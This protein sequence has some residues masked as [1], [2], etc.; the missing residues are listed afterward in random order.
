MGKKDYAKNIIKSTSYSAINVAST[1]APNSFAM[2]RGLQSV[3]PNI[4][5][6]NS[7][8]RTFISNSKNGIRQ[9]LKNLNKNPVARSAQE[10]L[11]QAKRDLSTGNFA[12][13]SQPVNF[14]DFNFDDFDDELSDAEFSFDDEPMGGNTS[15]PK[16]AK[17][18]GKSLH[19]NTYM[20]SNS[21]YDATSKIGGAILESHNQN[22]NRSLSAMM[23]G[24][25]KVD[26][27]LNMISNKL[28]VMNENLVNI[29][30]FNNN[31]ITKVNTAMLDYFDKSLEAMRA[32]GN[33]SLDKSKFTS[34]VDALSE[35]FSGGFSAKAYKKMVKK[36]F[37]NSLIGSFMS[38]FMPTSLSDMRD[39]KS[40]AQLFTLDNITNGKGLVQLGVEGLIKAA[41]PKDI[42][43]ST[44]SLD[45]NLQL[46]LK[47]SLLKLGDKG[48]EGLDPISMIAEIFGYKQENPNK[49]KLSAYKKDSMDWNGIAQRT[50]VD[51]I[52]SLLA[53]ISAGVNNKERE[54]YNFDK[55]KF[56]TKEDLEKQLRGTFEKDISVAM[57]DS[58]NLLNQKI[59]KNTKADYDKT[60]L[61]AE[62]NQLITKRL[63][64]EKTT[65]STFAPAMVEKLKDV[66]PMQD[67]RSIVMTM[68][69]DII[70]AREQIAKITREIADGYGEYSTFRQLLNK[71]AEIMGYYDDMTI[72][73]PE[74]RYNSSGDDLTTNSGQMRDT[75]KSSFQKMKDKLFAP[76]N[77]RRDTTSSVGKGYKK[78]LNDIERL[79]FDKIMNTNTKEIDQMADNNA[80]ELMI[81]TRRNEESAANVRAR[82][83][84]TKPSHTHRRRNSKS[85]GRRL[86]RPN[87]RQLHSI[88]G[89][90]DSDG[91]SD[92][93][94]AILSEDLSDISE[95]ISS[96]QSAVIEGQE[97]LTRSVNAQQAQNVGMFTKF[98]A[99]FA[100]K[101]FGK[102]GI[103]TKFMNNKYFKS[104]KDKTVKFLFGNYKDGKFDGES[105]LF[106]NAGNYILDGVDYLR[107]A[108]TGKGFKGRVMQGA[109][110]D[111]K[112]SVIGY[113]KDGFKK[114]YDSILHYMF[115][116]NY[117]EESD[118][119]KRNIQ[120]IENKFR[121]KAS[122]KNVDKE[123]ENKEPAKISM[124]GKELFKG[125]KVKAIHRGS[126]KTGDDVSVTE[127]ESPKEAIMRVTADTMSKFKSKVNKFT[128]NIVGEDEDKK[129]FFAKFK[130]HLPKILTAGL[131]GGGLVLASG[132]SVGLLPSLFL[133]NN[134]IGGAIV[135]MGALFASKSES[136]KKFLFGEKDELG[137]RNGGV[138]G[139]KLQSSFKKAL[140][141][142]IGAGALG[143]IRSMA[144]GGIGIPGAGFLMNI[145]TPGGVV[146]AALLS[147]AG[148]LA[149]KSNA[150]QSV[151]FGDL[152]KD[153]VFH[154]KDVE[155]K[156]SIIGRALNKV[157]AGLKGSKSAVING[158]KGAG[159]GLG[160][161]MVVSNLGVLGSAL[162]PAGPIGTA[163]L[164]AAVGIAS[165]SDKFQTLMFG[166]KKY[167]KDGNLI[168]GERYKDGLIS[169]MQMYIKTQVV[170]PT[171][172]TIQRNLVDFGLWTVKNIKTPFQLAFGPMIDSVRTMK[173]TFTDTIKKFFD[174]VSEGVISSIKGFFSPAAKFF[175]DYI[176]KP[177]GKTANITAKGGL[178]IAGMAIS[179]P[180]QVLSALMAPQRH[181]VEREFR[182]EY[183]QNSYQTLLNKWASDP[184]R[185]TDNMNIFQKLGEYGNRGFEYLNRFFDR[186]AIDDFREEYANRGYRVVP[187][188]SYDADG[189]RVV[190]NQVKYLNSLDWFMRPVKNRR[191]RQ[192][193]KEEWNPFKKND[194]AFQKARRNMVREQGGISDREYTED[195]IK[196]I[197]KRFKKFGVDSSLLRNTDDINSMLYNYDKWND[198][199][200]R[201]ERGQDVNSAEFIQERSKAEDR[202]WESQERFQENVINSFKDGSI[203]TTDTDSAEILQT[204]SDA[205]IEESNKAT[206]F[207]E[208][209]T[210]FFDTVERR[211]GES[212]QAET[213]GMV[214]AADL[215][216]DNISDSEF[217]R[218]VNKGTIT[219]NEAENNNTASI[220][221]IGNAVRDAA[222]DTAEGV[223]V[224]LE[225]MNESENRKNKRDIE[226]S[227][228]REREREET[229]AAKGQGYA[230]KQAKITNDGLVSSLLGSLG[231]NNSAKKAEKDS[232]FTK[233]F[234]GGK[235]LLNTALS[236]PAAFASIALGLLFG[237]SALTRVPGIVRLIGN[238]MTKIVGTISDILVKTLPTAI[239][240]V[241]DFT[242]D[243]VVD[244]IELAGNA[245]G[246]L[247]TENNR[248]IYD[249]YGNAEIIKDENVISSLSNIFLRN[250]ALVGGTVNKGF[251][252][253]GK[254]SR[255]IGNIFG[256]IG[257][258]GKLF[259]PKTYS[260]IGR[261]V[262]QTAQ[263]A[264]LEILDSA[265]NTSKLV[266][267]SDVVAKAQRVT[268]G[269]YVK[270]LS[271]IFNKLVDSSAKV[272]DKVLGAGTS[273]QFKKFVVE[274]V[275]TK[276][277]DVS[278]KQLSMV[279]NKLGEGIG[280][281]GGR[282][283]LLPITPIFALYDFSTGAFEAANL[284]AIDKS[285]VD[286]T[287]MFISAIMKTFFGL[288]P[289]PIFSL[290]LDLVTMISGFNMKRHIAETL[291]GI[292]KSFQINGAADIQGLKEAQDIFA[293]E[294]DKYNIDN[295]TS[296]S[297]EAYNDEKNK[298]IFTK[299]YN[300][301]TGKKERDYS[302]YENAAKMEYN[303]YY[304][305]SDSGSVT[306]ASA[307]IY[308]YNDY[309]AGYGDPYTDN[310]SAEISNPFV[311]DTS[312]KQNKA[313]ESF[314]KY[315]E[316]LLKNTAIG[317][318]LSAINPL[319]GAGY[320]IL[321]GMQYMFGPFFNDVRSIRELL[322]GR[323]DTAEKTVGYGDVPSMSQYDSRWSNYRI[324][325]LPNGKPSTM[326]TGG[327]GPTSLA[328]AVNAA[329]GNNVNPVSVAKYAKNN[330]YIVK[331]GSSS[332][333]FENGARAFG[334]AS[335][336][337]NPSS[338]VSNL[339]SGKP[340]VLSGKGSSRST[341]Y[342]PIGHIVT[343]T[344]IDR[345]NNVIVN[346]PRKSYVQKYPLSAVTRGMTNGWAYRKSRS[347]GY[348]ESP[349]SL[350]GYGDETSKRNWNSSTPE[351]G[352]IARNT[353]G[354][355][356]SDVRPGHLK[357]VM[358]AFTTKNNSIIKEISSYVEKKPSTFKEVV[359]G[360]MKSTF[361]DGYTDTEALEL[362]E[363]IATK[364]DLLKKPTKLNT[365]Y[366]ALERR[367]MK[368]KESGSTVNRSKATSLLTKY[369]LSSS[370]REALA[371]KRRKDTF[372]QTPE[373]VKGAATLHL[374]LD[375]VNGTYKISDPK[376]VKG[377][378]VTN[379]AT[380]NE[381]DLGQNNVYWLSNLDG[382]K[383]PRVEFPVKNDMIYYSQHYN[384]GEGL[385]ADKLIAGSKSKK[386]IH[387]GGSTLSALGMVLSSLLNKSVTPNYV[388]NKWGQ[389][390]FDNGTDS[391]DLAMYKKAAADVGLIAE[392]VPLSKSDIMDRLKKHIP[393][394]M[395]GNSNGI[396]GSIFGNGTKGSNTVVAYALTPNNDILY[397]DPS[398]GVDVKGAELLS[399]NGNGKNTF[400]GLKNAYAYMDETGSGYD[401]KVNKSTFEW[402]DENDDITGGGG[403]WDILREYFEKMAGYATEGIRSTI[404]GDEFK[405]PYADSDSKLL[406]SEDSIYNPD[407]T[408]DTG[409]DDSLDDTSSNVRKSILDLHN[410][411][412][413]APF[414]EIL[415]KDVQKAIAKATTKTVG[416]KK[417]NSSL[418]KLN[419]VPK[420]G[421]KSYG[422]VNPTLGFGDEDVVGY[423]E[424][425]E[426][427][428]GVPYYNQ[429]DPTWRNRR[430]NGDTIGKSGCV[431]SSYAMGIS[432]LTGK[433]YTPPITFERW[434]H[435]TSSGNIIWNQFENAVS[436]DTGIRFRNILNGVSANN[437]RENLEKGNP[438]IIYTK[439]SPSGN[440]VGTGNSNH[441]VLAVGLADNGK[442]VLIN[443][444]GD[445]GRNNTP[446][447]LTDSMLGMNRYR[448]SRM[449]FMSN[450]D[451]SGIKP[452]LLSGYTSTSDP[453]GLEAIFERIGAI[454]KAGIY[455]SLFGKDFNSEEVQAKF[456]LIEKMNDEYSSSYANV[457]GSNNAEKIWNYLKQNGYSDAA[458]AG[459]MAN[460]HHESSFNTGASGDN[461]TSYGICQWHKGRKDNLFK[462]AKSMGKD[463]SDLGVQ[464]S[465]LM[466][467]MT[468]SYP[469]FSQSSFKNITD[470]KEAAKIFC[471]KF[472]KPANASS[473]AIVRANTA[474][475]Y[476]S[477]YANKSVGYG[478][479]ILSNYGL[480]WEDV[481]NE[482]GKGSSTNEKR[483]NSI[484]SKSLYN[485]YRGNIPNLN[486]YEM[487]PD[488]QSIGYGDDVQFKKRM[489]DKL[490]VTVKTD[491]VENKL[492]ALIQVMKDWA[493][494][495][496]SNTQS[497]NITNISY[498]D[499]NVNLHTGNSDKKPVIINNSSPSSVSSLITTHR[500]ISKGTR[501]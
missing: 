389:M 230:A 160:T 171:A 318:G 447:P 108:F 348:G 219:Q 359:N 353:Y 195:E 19:Y 331:G 471:T 402:I 218:R 405:D 357:S 44:K 33:T 378:T 123:E 361:L 131:V 137:E 239:T 276:L 251:G 80:A 169:K 82:R 398:K 217:D 162:T 112:N 130:Q 475:S 466:D 14:D 56:V 153:G 204:T 234:E 343:A 210:K 231:F 212:I 179:S 314:Y 334:V 280:K 22:T 92:G 265:G 422:T 461:G 342:S 158:L 455:S 387:E 54:Y 418:L 63:R 8:M 425:Y 208:R 28:D 275:F 40:I 430:M 88:S 495:S 456:G 386:T 379:N 290:V 122:D 481:F 370:Q 90:E 358:K 43:S 303:P 392:N 423:G 399:A 67:I 97:A 462:K 3:T 168:E 4:S 129:A 174:K 135:G 163:V 2:G 36:N 349:S 364:T 319:L 286:K 157:S 492:D 278:P 458:A 244:T 238:G 201:M 143:V 240:K 79:T 184:S 173:D 498:G 139:Q 197:Q 144:G 391:F 161:G 12:K 241:F 11:E 487:Y 451:G 263:E 302:Y 500:E 410:E 468:T 182:K 29:V 363:Y 467:E 252:I 237:G 277:L 465:Y 46:L 330:N 159:I 133:P 473:K 453:D 333:L 194:K 103:I 21:I 274:K 324:G 365:V 261:T 446:I 459:I 187:K 81:D 281:V 13:K 397:H 128:D 39:L 76:F 74:V 227:E 172:Q 164:G 180:L 313:L 385:W 401:S 323:G 283:A 181:K 382:V 226:E 304:D 476:Y 470:P 111:Q 260:T 376:D 407:G 41:I 292:S 436:R 229:V 85:R 32:R 152:G 59:D 490:N 350:L 84:S 496:M 73:T 62:V 356:R 127:D 371:N 259:N 409:F 381:K 27:D 432:A 288:G 177:I 66:M 452:G 355:K 305:N 267:K 26:Y 178:K 416:P 307:V 250:P 296:L 497:N 87:R 394:L 154:R 346:D 9:Q 479:A 486:D 368:I 419:T 337:V 279:V 469:I 408:F 294:L 186:D 312:S 209:A 248:T 78:I 383:G 242:Q 193:E 478:D 420:K 6:L 205:V 7:K 70:G 138:F 107:H 472:E 53:D 329:T 220:M 224:G 147:M 126:I 98:F 156:G 228:R 328:M 374:K 464:L 20:T 297:L 200:T 37:N 167:D 120:P 18:I 113:M 501:G 301:V 433:D 414:K 306:K 91:G 214:D 149:L 366:D 270:I 86:A 268:L 223:I 65:D 23:T 132:G 89:D 60:S 440:I 341:P 55:G 299:V 47:H 117:K 125:T 196:N 443:D 377:N 388:A 150:F 326:A 93:S 211:L 38:A 338:I 491:G 295:Q 411:Q 141:V 298:G 30:K 253:F 310:T 435:F 191:L 51:V 484:T 203:K 199:R 106:K 61:I 413:S 347:I 95:A 404:M 72:M 64:N 439:K 245:M 367:I 16:S 354:L 460:I 1:I 25:S 284:F 291:Y 69:S 321:R 121:R 384:N 5:D 192:W 289:M 100:S 412:V 222:Q 269:S 116:K 431:L 442:K 483:V 457:S 58:I 372:F 10:A 232:I 345:N 202:H 396:R 375:D 24:F 320:T 188:V 155:N 207:R 438:A 142:A 170:E 493:V 45:K 434:P 94:S 417:T 360:R 489:I 77:R 427:A 166:S 256:K 406:G 325:T 183:R 448:N 145:F 441:A 140:P 477:K 216:S 185:N 104:I 151:L 322:S 428:N 474:S 424:G 254:A 273:T 311:E 75:A 429:G 393:V 134:I 42:K 369:S 463:P 118:F 206:T 264:T 255:G 257:D 272:I 235:N 124:A 488:V 262:E 485:S 215:L 57:Y 102:N 421:K 49:I 35:I 415:P 308:G 317:A 282:V 109:E 136:V 351:S 380:V 454:G 71:N 213:S 176:L 17:F 246:I 258:F 340:V 293:N 285:E 426:T 31:N 336:K 148:A 243:R 83:A 449:I 271:N 395:R 332:G 119:Y 373:L 221:A 68:E 101:I 437:L 300:F 494:Y 390:F 339:R 444:P 52:P 175:M 114:A 400:K 233:I 352:V 316:K 48:G 190:Q 146:G 236:N 198:K 96:N 189:N 15:K 482:D 287:M 362:F 499:R 99:P 450:A 225:T 34:D 480:N 165:V 105:G 335:S 327:C 249:E 445:R 115:G 309:N 50:L 247:D 344:G 403:I 315:P 266:L 110:D